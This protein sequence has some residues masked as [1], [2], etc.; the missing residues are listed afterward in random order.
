MLVMRG[1][2]DFTIYPDMV[3]NLI[4]DTIFLRVIKISDQGLSA[5]KITIAGNNIKII[6]KVKNDG[7]P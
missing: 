1:R 5:K 6:N 7:L 4:K 2:V 3:S